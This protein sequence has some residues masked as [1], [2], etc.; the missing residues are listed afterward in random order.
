M[1]KKEG[2]SGGVME[3]IISEKAVISVKLQRFFI[4]GI[5]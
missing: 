3:G 5:G 4:S 1:V 2:D